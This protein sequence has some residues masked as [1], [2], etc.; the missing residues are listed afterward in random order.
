MAAPAHRA[1][2]LIR[3]AALAALAAAL[4]FTFGV[5]RW[6]GVLR[7]GPPEYALF[8][9]GE[10]RVAIDPGNAPF[11]FPGGSG[12]SGIEPEL[13]QALGA[14]LGVPVRFVP[15]GFDGL[16]D[17]LQTDQADVVLAAL[18]PNPARTGDVAYSLPYFNAGQVLVVNGS[19]PP[20]SL[21]EGF[22]GRVALAYGTPEQTQA[23]RWLRLVPPFTIASYETAEI[24]LDA[25]R[26]GEADA[27]LTDAVSVGRYRAAHP[28]WEASLLPVTTTPYAAAL[29]LDRPALVQQFNRAL[30]ELMADGTLNAIL[31]RYLS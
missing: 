31:S 1:V 22:A 12:Y 8:P 16:Y 14:R 13:A 23:E 26:L 20:A 17:A 10:L 4:L 2:A 9:Y 24:A 3:A 21:G 7:F 25:L 30:E 18:V 15:H 11:A 19:A 5:L 6:N 27:A 28:G 29:R